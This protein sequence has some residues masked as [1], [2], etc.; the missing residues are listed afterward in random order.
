MSKKAKLSMPVIS[1]RFP[2]IWMAFG[3]LLRLA[4]L[5]NLILVLS[6]ISLIQGK[7]TTYA[8]LSKKE[9]THTHVHIQLTP[10]YLGL[11]SDVYRLISFNLGVMEEIML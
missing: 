10:F 1:Q 5:M 7:N 2:S 6:H 4:G 9:H 11:Q 8:I 3:T